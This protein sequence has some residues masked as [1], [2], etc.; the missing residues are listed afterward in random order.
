MNQQQIE[1][2]ATQID[3][4]TPSEILEL[5]QLAERARMTKVSTERVPKLPVTD[6]DKDKLCDCMVSGTFYSET[7]SFF[8]GK[9]TATFRVKTKQEDD[10]IIS[11]IHDDFQDSVIKSSAQYSNRLAV[12]QLY[13]QTMEL[14][15][16]K[17]LRSKGKSLREE[18][19]N[20]IFETMPE[21]KLFLLITTLNQFEAKVGDILKEAL[22]SGFTQPGAAS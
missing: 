20:S 2:E 8:K 22:D 13:I 21:P 15:G 11:Q 7:F 14:G 4:L 10:E 18:V 6:A 16:V 1:Q 5:R 9:L 3:Q 17:L 19:K 12:Y